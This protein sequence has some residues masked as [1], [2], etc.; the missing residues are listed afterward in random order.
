M[1]SLPFSIYKQS[2]LIHRAWKFRPKQPTL[3]FIKQGNMTFRVNDAE[4]IYQTNDI[5]FLSDRNMYEV[6][7]T[8]ENT[9]IYQ[10]DINLIAYKKLNF[11]FNRF[12]MYRAVY[13]EPRNRIPVSAENFKNSILP[14]LDL[15][16]YQTTK[17]RDIHYGKEILSKLFGA[18]IYTIVSQGDKMIYGEFEDISSRKKQL[19]FKFLEI[20]TNDFS[21]DKELKYYSDKLNISI[22]YLSICVKEVIGFPPTYILTQLVLKEAC[23]RLADDYDTI[24]NIAYDLK[25]ADLHSFSKFFKKHNGISPSQFRKEI[26]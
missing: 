14:L 2:D 5:V 12:E 11:R 16:Y 6:V 19:A 10:L 26:E 24:A 8:S 17:K 9:S 18:L 1:K 21:N 22:K 15:I 3:L 20:A 13:L 25:F 4:C 23:N 7:L